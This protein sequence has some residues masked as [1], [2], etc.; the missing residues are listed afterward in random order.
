MKK[1]SNC[2]GEAIDLD[3]NYA[4]AHA[5]LGWSYI[6]MFNLDTRRPIGEFTDRALD[7]G[8]KA[9]TLD[10]QEPWGHLVSGLGS[11]A[12]ASFRAGIDSSVEIRRA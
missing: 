7:A 10:D 5:L 11:R 4:H 12:P 9:V 3:A 2:C 6:S 1:P 8:S